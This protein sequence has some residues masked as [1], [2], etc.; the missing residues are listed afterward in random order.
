MGKKNYVDEY[1]ITLPDIVSDGNASSAGAAYAA[2]TQKRYDDTEAYKKA[3]R[4]A[5]RKL[6]KKSST[7]S[8]LGLVGGL[9]A[10]LLGA[11]P[12]GIGVATALGGF[13]GSKMT[14]DVIQE[15]SD[16]YAQFNELHMNDQGVVRQVVI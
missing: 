11:G 8:T 5:Q 14:G 4:R 3:V 1:G 7:A 15:F 9:A 12:L 2:F 6:E 10:G 13:G 16:S